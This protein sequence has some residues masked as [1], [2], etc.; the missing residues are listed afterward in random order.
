VLRNEMVLVLKE[1]FNLVRGRVSGTSALWRPQ[2][3]IR[4]GDTFGNKA[5]ADWTP[6]LS[7]PMHPEYPSGHCAHPSRH[8]GLAFGARQGQRDHG[9]QD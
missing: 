8:G 3:A 9:D 1:C 2:T 7:T 5:V 6:Q 4:S